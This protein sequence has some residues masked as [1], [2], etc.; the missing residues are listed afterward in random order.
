MLN[1][2]SSVPLASIPSPFSHTQLCLQSYSFSL[3]IAVHSLWV[4]NH[5]LS[6][7]FT[8]HT[9]SRQAFLSL[10]TP[11][12]QHGSWMS[13][14]CISS[15]SLELKTLCQLPTTILPQGHYLL[16]F[17]WPA[18]AVAKSY[19]LIPLRL[20]THLLHGVLESLGRLSSQHPTSAWASFP[21]GS[22]TSHLP[23]RVWRLSYTLI[24]ILLCIIFTSFVSITASFLFFLCYLS[25]ASWG[26]LYTCFSFFL[27]NYK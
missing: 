27:L 8:L 9:T 3:S 11:T 22:S 25:S 24:Y 19:C 16:S 21:W 5:S 6:I 13:D 15:P 20:L 17:L 4:A 10:S 18:S 12:H 2:L 1:T 23:A 26:I 7:Q 14:K